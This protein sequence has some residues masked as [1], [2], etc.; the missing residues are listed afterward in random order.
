MAAFRSETE[1]ENKVWLFRVFF[2][3]IALFFA[4]LCLYGIGNYWQWGHDGYMGASMSQAA[5]N[6]L[7][8]GVVG[9]AWQ[10]FGFEPPKPADF[11][12]NHPLLLNFHLIVAHTL[13]GFSEW[14]ARLVPLSYTLALFVLLWFVVRHFYGQLTAL[15]AVSIYAL[16]PQDVIFAHLVSHEQGG[17]FWCLAAL[18]VHLYWHERQRATRRAMLSFACL[19]MA[20]QYDWPGYYLAFFIWL[21]QL[22]LGFALWKKHRQWPFAWSLA[23]VLAVLVWINAF[24]FFGWIYHLKG[25]LGEMIASFRMRSQPLDW[26]H[27]LESQ[28]QWSKDLRGWLPHVLLTSWLLFRLLRLAKGFVSRDMIPFSF[29]LI[30]LVQSTLFKQAGSLH[31]YWTLYLNIAIA[32]GG[33][34]LLYALSL[35]AQRWFRFPGERSVLLLVVGLFVFQAPFTVR[36]LRWAVSTGHAS[37]VEPYPE[38][39]DKA[40]WFK[41]L[42]KR[43]G[44]HTHYFIDRSLGDVRIELRYYLDAPNEDVHRFILP[45]AKKQSPGKN[46]LLIDKQAVR[47]KKVLD[48][49]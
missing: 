42:G 36:Q 16:I 18:G 26:K 41:E 10:Y 1:L 39:F 47:N 7:R 48:S 2:L 40:M 17:M 6:S 49:F 25:G 28:W 30:Q 13:F 20:M 22:G 14:A 27:Y 29:L 34:E 37:Y 44:R 15:F 31:A 11:Y 43:Y 8:F 5:R 46:V 38:Q 33:A 3:A 12:T 19:C 32:V 9:Q 24:V 35:A 4:L 23:L 45:V 21:H